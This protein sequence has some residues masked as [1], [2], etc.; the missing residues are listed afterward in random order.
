MK[1]ASGN[2]RHVMKT[3]TVLVILVIKCASTVA[4]IVLLGV[5]TEVLPLELSRPLKEGARKREQRRRLRRLKC[6]DTCGKYFRSK[7]NR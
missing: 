1:L 7:G 6:L 2:K 4:I 3:R 5:K